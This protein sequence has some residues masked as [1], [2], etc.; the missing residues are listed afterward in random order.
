M[1]CAHVLVGLHERKISQ[2]TAVFAIGVSP[3]SRMLLI[4][5][6]LRHGDGAYCIGTRTWAALCSHR[7]RVSA[8]CCFCGCVHA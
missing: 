4:I 5:P 1:L 2:V 3:C 8:C 7:K 6:R